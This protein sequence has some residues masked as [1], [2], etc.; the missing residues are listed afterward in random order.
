MKENR[1]LFLADQL[2][3]RSSRRR[4][5]FTLIELLVVI[6]IIAI[7]AGMLLPALAKAKEKAKATACLSNSRQIG[8]ALIMYAD[9]HNDTIVPLEILGTPPSDAYV[10]RGGTIWWPDLLKDYL[11]NKYASDCPSTVGT[12]QTGI[13]TGPPSTRGKGRFGIGMNH[14]EFSYSPWAGN[15][16]YS[17]KLSS[18][19]KPA[20]SVVFGDAG[21][22]QNF[23][24][25]DPDQWKEIR[26]AQLLYFLT[27]SHPDY[28][29][30]NPHRMINRHGGRAMS[31]WADGHGESARVSKIGFQFYPGVAPDGSQAK[32]DPIIGVGNGK[33]DPR[34]LWDRE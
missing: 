18:V 1:S 4:P 6:A 24:E 19:K 17:I 23:R 11:P 7:L 12:N 32:G 8:L 28:A 20:E 16:I 30:N 21:K 25:K 5:A 33:Y 13:P 34:W 26:G 27:P 14:I 10:P 29:L 3:R 31:T 2:E 22:V 9:D 15:Q